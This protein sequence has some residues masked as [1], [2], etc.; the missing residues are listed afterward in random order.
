MNEYF[1]EINAI[2]V[3]WKGGDRNLGAD[4]KGIVLV[5]EWMALGHEGELCNISN[6]P[7]NGI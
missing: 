7:L 1:S 4:D 5:R 3:I 6:V 2:E